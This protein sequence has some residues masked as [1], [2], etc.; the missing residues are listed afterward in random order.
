M[1]G[2]DISAETQTALEQRQ[3]VARD[4]IWFEVRDRETGEPVTDGYWSDLGTRNFEVIDPDT[5]LPVTRT[6]RGGANLIAIPEIPLVSNLTVQTITVT[7]SQLSPRVNEL[8]RLYDPKL[9]RV[10][11]HRGLFNINTRLPVAPAE[12]RFVG[13]I[14]GAPVETPK[15]GEV[16]DVQVSVVGHSQEWSRSNPDTRNHESQML[17]TPE[18]QPPDEFMKDVAVV[19]DWELF[20]GKLP[21]KVPSDKASRNIKGRLGLFR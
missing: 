13:F 8:L 15:E 17:R 7:L 16:G 6:Y 12:V 5:G 10:E 11:I 20:W 4:F 9:G 21:G 1:T 18:G 3:I 2:R 14:D 19:G